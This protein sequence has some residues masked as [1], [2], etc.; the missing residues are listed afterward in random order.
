MNGRKLTPVELKYIQKHNRHLYLESIIGLLFLLFAIVIIDGGDYYYYR[1]SPEEMD[2]P[3]I[4]LAIVI[5]HVIILSG[6]IL[7]GIQKAKKR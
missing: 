4:T 3:I 2:K 1:L 7:I 5:I 6:F